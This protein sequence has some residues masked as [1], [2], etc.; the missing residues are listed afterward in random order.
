M[1]DALRELVVSIDFDDVDIKTLLALD[2][3]I[4]EIEDDL[5]KMG[6]EIDEA[7]AEF[8]AMGAAGGSALND[9]QGEAGR[10]SRE[11]SDL[12]DEINDA[13]RDLLLLGAA[14]EALNNV[15]NEAEDAADEMDDLGN[16]IKGVIGRIMALSATAGLITLAFSGAVAAAA[17]LIAGVMAL[18]ASFAAAGIGAAAFGAVAIP[19]LS[20]IFK[21]SKDI[22]KLQEK[23]ANA[24]TAK[25]RLKAQQEL[26]EI[27]AGMSKAQQ[28]ALKQL[29]AFKVFWADF[30]KAFETPVFQAF[31]E[32]LKGLKTVLNELKPTMLNVSAV[33]VQLMRDFNESLKSADVQKFFE[34]LEVNAAESLNNFAAIFGNTF[35]GIM[36]VLRAFAPMGASIEEW[37]LRMSQRFREWAASLGESSAFQSFMSYVQTNGPILVDILSNIVKIGG[38]LITAF[39]PLGTEVLEVVRSF[40]DF[41]ANEVTPK[42]DDIGQKAADFVNT[43]Q[44]NWPAIRETVIGLAVAV[45]TFKAAMMGLAFIEVV[46][47][48]LNGFRIALQLATGA[49]V[50]LNIAMLAN[51]ATLVAAGIAA[52]VAIGVVLYRNW[53]TI[54]AKAIEL[55]NRFTWIRVAAIALLGPFGAVIAMGVAL[56]RNW[57]TIKEKASQLGNAIAQKW[58][59]IRSAT[60]SAWNSVKSAISNAMASAKSS[61][62][63]FFGGISGWIESAKAKWNSFISALRNFKMPKLS[64]PKINFPKPPAW[65]AKVMGSHATGL[66]RVPF[67]GYIAELHK[68]EAVLTAKQA[69]ALRE[70]GILS[71]Q[72]G[73]PKLNFEQSAIQAGNIQ[74]SSVATGTSETSNMF[75]PHIEVKV[76]VESGQGDKTNI[77]Q[78]VIRAAQA[79]AEAAKQEL[80]KFWL[81]M[82]MKFA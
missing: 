81:Q 30:T 47:G 32:G 22:E 66:A 1:S 4:D 74:K 70:A 73:K 21:K 72:N 44:N 59:A 42:L 82:N 61:V 69:N 62:S 41:L 68:D 38:D 28:E 23:I 78:A 10:A 15:E 46:T 20:D 60:S 71:S 25:E 40:T 3:A 63:N 16:K 13:A 26:A 39:A 35:M 49:Q 33:V 52:L 36:N 54:K 12:Q 11:M 7:T 56:Y 2:S 6:R 67:D 53:D 9:I 64:F 27:Y 79:G 5:R 34:W 14:A 51:P 55:W 48:L 19:I 24:D 18:G 50:G 57:D 76:Y 29:Q 75:A 43:V 8:T 77:E 17:P 58:A 65:L 31:A 37:L 45:G 80:E